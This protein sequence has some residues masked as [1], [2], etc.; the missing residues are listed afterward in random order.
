MNNISNLIEY[1]KYEKNKKI[2]EK[3]NI[4]MYSYKISYPELYDK[5]EC[6]ICFENL[7]IKDEVYLIKCGHL[8]HKKCLKLWIQKYNINC[9]TCRVDI[10]DTYDNYNNGIKKIY[11]NRDKLYKKLYNKYITKEELI[12]RELCIF[13]YLLDI[14]PDKPKNIIINMIN[15]KIKNIK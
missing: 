1:F 3:D 4:N 8:F 2:D 10:K 12:D 9:P 5:K 11:N 15:K 13:T 14:S 6:P 7:K